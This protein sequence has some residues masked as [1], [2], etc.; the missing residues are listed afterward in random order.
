ML[1][2]Y[3]IISIY[4]AYLFLDL[5]RLNFSDVCLLIG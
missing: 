3:D 2:L 4:T 5:Y 1:H